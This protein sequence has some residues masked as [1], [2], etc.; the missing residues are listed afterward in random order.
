[1][2]KENHDF[3]AV[4]LFGIL[5]SF[6]TYGYVLHGIKGVYSDYNGHTYVYLP[7]FSK[8]TWVEGWMMVPYCM[9]HLVTLFFNKCLFVPVESAAAYTTCL[10]VLFAYF[11]AYWMVRKVT[12]AAGSVDSSLRAA[13][14]AFGLCAG[15]AFSFYWLDENARF[16]MNPIYNP[17]YMCVRGFSLVCFCL[18]GDIWGRQKDVNYRGIF[19]RVENGLKRYYIYLAILLFLSAMAK[20]TFAEMFIPAVAFIMLGE[21]IAKLLRKDGSAASYFRQCLNMLWCAVPTLLYILLQFLVYFIWGGSYDGGGGL[22]VTKWLEVWRIFTQNVGLSIVCGMAFPLFMVL[23]DG[24]FFV[25]SDWGRLAL[26]GFLAGFLEAALL[27][28]G[29]DKLTHGDFFWPMMSGMLLMFAVSL[30]RLLVLE[31]TQADTR[32]RKILLAAA[33]FLFGIHV[34]YGLINFLER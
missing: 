30:M 6:L 2:K 9:W 29:G 23:I 10:F 13:A 19:F 5:L 4:L 26:A 33:W 8:E 15:Q 18:V 24:T 14:V 25:K 21:W 31:R 7:M 12:E 11:V 20:P 28:E 17:T 22:I 32:G 3:L 16:S 34:M 1:M 27:G